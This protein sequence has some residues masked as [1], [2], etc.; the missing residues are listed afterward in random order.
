[1]QRCGRAAWSPSTCGTTRPSTRSLGDS[2]RGGRK[3][4]SMWAN[5]S[6]GRA[7]R[8]LFCRKEVPLGQSDWPHFDGLQPSRFQ[9]S[10]CECGTGPQISV[11]ERW[12]HYLW[13]GDCRDKV[14]VWP[15]P[16]S[17]DG[18]GN[19]SIRRMVSEAM[20]RYQTGY[21]AEITESEEYGDI[22]TSL[23][24]ATQWVRDCSFSCDSTLF[25]LSNQA[26]SVNDH[27]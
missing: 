5:G 24:R 27:R 3:P 25:I 8:G 2:P 12:Y 10:F 19:V 9:I 22:I 11:E 15:R 16:V 23:Q 20:S 6:R 26:L 4:Q 13:D 18:H 14:A 21:N 7:L 1:M 17:W